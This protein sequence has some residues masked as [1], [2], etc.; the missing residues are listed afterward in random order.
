MDDSYLKKGVYIA[1]VHFLNGS[2]SNRIT[3]VIQN[4]YR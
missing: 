1:T 4:L 3:A 2:K